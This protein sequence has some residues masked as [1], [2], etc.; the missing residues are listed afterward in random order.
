MVFG[1]GSSLY[2]MSA[3]ALQEYKDRFA[4]AMELAGK[5]AHDIAKDLDVTYQAIKKILNGGTKMPRADHSAKAALAMDVDH[6]WLSTGVGLA[7]GTVAQRDSVTLEQSL[8]VVLQALATAPQ[9]D[10]LKTVLT[11][12]LEDDS[13]AYRQRL[14]E[15]LQARDPAPVQVSPTQTAA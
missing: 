10:K 4:Y 2:G 11:A 9:R 13:P 5:S 1:P 15:L 3:R 8:N 12:L 6:V 14:A 7:R